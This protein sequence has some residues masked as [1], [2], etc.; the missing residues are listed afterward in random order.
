M[1]D[2]VR[3]EKGANVMWPSSLGW[4]LKPVCSQQARG[5]PASWLTPASSVSPSEI[6]CT[7]CKGWDGNQAQLDL[8]HGAKIK[9][10]TQNDN[11]HGCTCNAKPNLDYD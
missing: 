5:T 8:V 1:G 11:N 6:K 2:V 7:N 10:L 9:P 3:D 4:T